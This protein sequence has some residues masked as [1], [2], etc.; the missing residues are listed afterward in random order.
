VNGQ[1]RIYENLT[2]TFST[3]HGK[4]HLAQPAFAE[5]LGAT[6]T[7]PAGLNTDTFGTFSGEIARR[8]DA[9]AAARA[10]ARRGM[11]L[12]RNPRGL[13]SEGS[14]SA[15]FGSLL[16]HHELLLFIDDTR[17]IELVEEHV[18]L[19][20]IPAGHDVDAAVDVVHLA[21]DM[22]FPENGVVLVGERR[23]HRTVVKDVADEAHLVAATAALVNSKVS[24][25]RMTPDH[26]AHRAP[27]RAAVI[28]SLSDR[29]AHRIATPCPQC[30]CP[31]FG[32]TDSAPGLPCETCEFPTDAIR[33]DVSSC[34]RCSFREY[35]PRT[36]VSASALWCRWCNP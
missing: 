35:H 31:G 26:R 33:A 24:R 6:V 29:M 32:V 2:V 11:R 17:G 34:C 7:A 12:A 19:T 16:E 20:S 27:Y 8:L 9:L 10:K 14:F 4:H 13:A 21:H 3:M 22:G 1:P 25:V 18:E 28:R 23:R 5:I 15:S 30:S 36:E